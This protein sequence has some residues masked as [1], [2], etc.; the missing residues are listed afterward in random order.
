MHTSLDREMF[1]ISGLILAL[2][3]I[4][5]NPLQLGSNDF[6][7]PWPLQNLYRDICWNGPFCVCR[8]KSVQVTANSILDKL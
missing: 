5:K 1:D 6:P 4:P 7:N 8:A 3:G 2:R